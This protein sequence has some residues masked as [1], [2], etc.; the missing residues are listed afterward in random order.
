M[1][2]FGQRPSAEVE[3]V[4]RIEGDLKERG[5]GQSHVADVGKQY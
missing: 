1:H 5:G 3:G 4:R 2:I